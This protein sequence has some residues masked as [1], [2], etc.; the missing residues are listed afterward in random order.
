[1]AWRE[2]PACR[3]GADRDAD[4]PCPHCG[5]EQDEAERL[6][7]GSPAQYQ[8]SGSGHTWKDDVSALSGI[9][10]LQKRRRAAQQPPDTGASVF[11]ITLLVLL[12][13]TVGLWLWLG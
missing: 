8:G 7:A 9:R 10:S 1:M 13:L 5:A 12:A 6:A 2:C 4:D 11:T 3:K